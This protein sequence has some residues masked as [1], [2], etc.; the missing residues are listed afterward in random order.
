VGLPGSVVN[1]LAIDPVVP[2][3]IF[4]GV[5]AGGAET[6]LWRSQDSGKTWVKVGGG[7]PDRYYGYVTICPLSHT[8]LANPGVEGIWHSDDGGDTWIASTSVLTD[9]G[10]PSGVL[11][12]PSAYYVVWTVSSQTGVY[13]S[14]DAGASFVR[15][16]N[17]GLPLN[18]FGLGPLAFDGTFL[19]LGTDGHGIYQSGDM[20]ASWTAAP[21][22]GLPT[23]GATGSVVN[24]AATLAR[25]SVL[26]VKTNGALFR[27]LDAAATFV[28][29]DPGAGGVRYPALVFDP[30]NL[31]TLYTSA[32]EVQSGMGGLLKTSDDGAT[33]INIGPSGGSVIAV[34]VGSDG[35]LFAG[36]L[37]NGV[38][39]YGR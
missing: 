34:A 2:T 13:R 18:Q 35:T 26:F 19:Y 28:A 1:A 3:T 16:S 17:T 15:A 25:P 33:W 24:L 4:A 23:T 21:S 30:M 27:S 36:T 20:G 11:C 6:G 37:G 14:E 39:R 29:L 31:A 8:I 9:P 10:N 7:L 38:W 5:G 32:S 12:H 22:V